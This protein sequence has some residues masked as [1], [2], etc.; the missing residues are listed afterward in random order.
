MLWCV[1]PPAHESSHTSFAR[2]CMRRVPNWPL[3]QSTG[4][5]AP[6]FP[7]NV[8][9][10]LHSSDVMEEVAARAKKVSGHITEERRVKA[11]P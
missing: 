10:M 9:S 11:G 7:D 8:C 3:C 1:Y 5:Q 6:H 4:L 2:R